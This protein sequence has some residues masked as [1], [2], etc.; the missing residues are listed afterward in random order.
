VAEVN[1]AI[2]DLHVPG[3]EASEQPRVQ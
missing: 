1:V 3:D 2:N